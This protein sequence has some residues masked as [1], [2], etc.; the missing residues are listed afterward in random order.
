MNEAEENVLGAYVIVIKQPCFFLGKYYYS[1]GP[2]GE[3]FK[4][5]ITSK[6]WRSVLRAPRG[7]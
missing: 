2:V 5:L 3:S 1:P 7:V 6:L 4:H